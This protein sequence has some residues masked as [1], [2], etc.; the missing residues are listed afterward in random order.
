M[1]EGPYSDAPCEEAIKTVLADRQGVPWLRVKL[2]PF[3]DRVG[4][5]GYE[6]LRQQVVGN[7][8]IQREVLEAIAAELGVHPAYF[9]EYR[10]MEISGALSRVSGETAIGVYQM[11]M[12]EGEKPERQSA[13]SPRRG[14]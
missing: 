14:K 4:I 10:A 6:A 8:P 9:R 3:L 2:K 7:T 13:D 11:L 12:A 1:Y 5:L